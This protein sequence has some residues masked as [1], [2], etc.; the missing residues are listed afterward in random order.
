MLGMGEREVN[1]LDPVIKWAMAS[2][3]TT[4]SSTSELEGSREDGSQKGK[5]KRRRKEKDE[6]PENVRQCKSVLKDARE[7]FETH[8]NYY[9][10][11]LAYYIQGQ[12]ELGRTD[13]DWVEDFGP[14]YLQGT[15]QWTAKVRDA[16]AACDAAFAEWKVEEERK[17]TAKEEEEEEERKA[18][19]PRRRLFEKCSEEVMDIIDKI[20]ASRRLRDGGRA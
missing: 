17:Q 4:E 15:V 6:L 5:R 12:L 18:N 7:E 14:Q 9:W 20:G 10:Q 16:E 3:W 13:G 8:Q 11:F 2:T 1:S 19:P